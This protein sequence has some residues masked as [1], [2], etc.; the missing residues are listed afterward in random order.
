MKIASL[1]KGLVYGP[2][3]DTLNPPSSLIIPNA[4]NSSTTDWVDSNSDGEPDMWSHSAAHLTPS[5]VT[6]NGFTGNAVRLDFLS[7]PSDDN[8]FVSDV[9]DTTKYKGTTKYLVFDARCSTTVYCSVKVDGGSWVY[10]GNYQVNTGDAILTGATIGF[11]VGD[12]LQVG[13]R[14]AGSSRWTEI[15]NVILSSVVR[16]REFGTIPDRIGIDNSSNIVG[17]ES[18]LE[19][20]FMHFGTDSTGS[21]PYFD[22][23]LYDVDKGFSVSLKFKHDNTITTNYLWGEYNTPGGQTAWTKFFFRTSSNKLGVSAGHYPTNIWFET[24]TLV[25]GATYNVVLLVT[26]F[27]TKVYLN[28]ELVYTDTG[29]VSFEGT[30]GFNRGFNIWYTS[31]GISN[32]KHALLYDRILSENEIDLLSSY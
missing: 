22:E 26:R 4:G 30:G 10:V 28:N 3:F 6:G 11:V 27:N 16:E 24:S 19:G 9:I 32:I 17:G 23:S 14:M 1:Y 5:I 13:F 20:Q 15:D 8:S 21:M 31:R 25:D 18:V 7:N 12:T 2:R 29:E